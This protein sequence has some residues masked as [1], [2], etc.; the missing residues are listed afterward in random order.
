[1]E[2]EKMEES[3][4][5]QILV[6]ARM[7]PVPNLETVRNNMSLMGFL[8]IIL[9]TQTPILRMEGISLPVELYNILLSSW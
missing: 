3:N 8:D 6:N 7:A 2:V 9:A 1:V 4:V 5:E